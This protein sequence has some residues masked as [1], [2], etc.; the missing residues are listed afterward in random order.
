MGCM[1]VVNDDGYDAVDE[2]VIDD[3]EHHDHPVSSTLQGS[4]S[5]MMREEMKGAGCMMSKLPKGPTVAVNCGADDGSVNASD[6]ITRSKSGH[7]PSSISHTTSDGTCGHTSTT[8]HH[9]TD[10]H[11][12]DHESSYCSCQVGSIVL[13]RHTVAK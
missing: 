4:R 9:T 1:P 2:M 13:S 12:T 11:T 8:D 3:E 6:R 10:H 7:L 5:P